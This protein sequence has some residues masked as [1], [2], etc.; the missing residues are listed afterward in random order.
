MSEEDRVRAQVSEA[1]RFRALVLEERRVKAQVSE[2]GR[3][4]AQCLREVGL[5][6]KQRFDIG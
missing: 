5:G 1:S 6:L 3:F 2:E 4:R